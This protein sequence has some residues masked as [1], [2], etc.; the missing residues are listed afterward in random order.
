MIINPSEFQPT[1]HFTVCPN[2][3]HPFFRYYNG[4]SP[5]HFLTKIPHSVRIFSLLS[6]HYDPPHLFNPDV[7]VSWMNHDLPLIVCLELI[8]HS[9]QIKIFCFQKL[10]WHFSFRTPKD[11]TCCTHLS[12]HINVLLV[13]DSSPLIY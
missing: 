3:E 5:R 13:A 7:V 1:P 11:T 12:T 6:V 9:C 2:T 10:V 8:I 4:S